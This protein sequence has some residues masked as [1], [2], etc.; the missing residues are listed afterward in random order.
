M[1][2]TKQSTWQVLS[3]YNAAVLWPTY[4]GITAIH[5]GMDVLLSNSVSL[6]HKSRKFQIP[7]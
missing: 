1:D 2:E 5:W 3:R 4:T 7:P 6:S